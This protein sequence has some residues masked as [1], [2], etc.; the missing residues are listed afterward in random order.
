MQPQRLLLL[1]VLL[2]MIKII[3]RLEANT[4]NVANDDYSNS[5]DYGD[6]GDRGGSRDYEPK[7]RRFPCYSCTYH[8]DPEYPQGDVNCRDPF[9]SRGIP[10]VMCNESCAL[11]QLGSI[12][13]TE[14]TV[15]RSC[16]K[17]CREVNS[18]KKI[19][20]C[21]NTKLCNDFRSSCDSRR[22]MDIYVYAA[23]PMFVIS[24]V[25]SV[26]V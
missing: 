7:Q 1:P 10:E 26:F 2:L 17:N 24:L 22:P 25:K 13:A 9:N 21:C 8:H 12:N 5:Y 18:E 20:K 19:I 15:F 16:Q 6:Y 3:P 4:Q 23:F 14:F 11:I